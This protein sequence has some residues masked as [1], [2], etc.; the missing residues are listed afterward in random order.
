VRFVTLQGYDLR[1]FKGPIELRLGAYRDDDLISHAQRQLYD[2]IGTDQVIWCGRSDPCLLAQSGKYLHYID[3]DQRDIV[4]VIDSLMWCHILNYG[5]RYIPDEE[6]T[7]LRNHARIS[8]GDFE[9]SL[10]QAEDEYLAKHR[11]A[12]LWSH[13]ARESLQKESDQLLLAFPFSHST[14]ASVKEITD[15]MA[16]HDRR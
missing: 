9:T 4:R 12:D 14:V 6:R 7:Q 11:P 13:V 2:K 16:K 10:R 15:L 5:S 8:D 1:I 3:V